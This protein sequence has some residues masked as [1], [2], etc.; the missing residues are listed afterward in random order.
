MPG[1]ADAQDAEE[2]GAQDDLAAD[3][4]GGHRRDDEPQ[5]VVIVER[6]EAGA[7]PVDEREDQADDPGRAQ[8]AARQQAAFQAQR[9]Q[10]VPDPLV[11]RQEALGAG[12]HLSE[13]R[14][15]HR[16]E[17][18]DDHGG[19]GDEGVDVEGHRADVERPGDDGRPD[20]DAQDEDHQAR[21][22]EQ[23]ARAEQQQE[24][25][26]TPPVPPG[27]QMRRPAPAVLGQRGRDLG[28]P[29][30]GQRRLDHKLAGE[31]HARGLQPEPHDTVPAETA[32][33]A[34]EVTDLAAEEQPADETEHRVAEVAVQRRH[35]PRLDAALK[36][37]A[38]HQV[39]PVPELLHERHQ[40]G[41]V[42]T[43]VRVAH[44]DAAT[45]GGHNPAH[46]GVAV[47]LLGD[48][49]HA[50]PGVGGQ[51]LA[52]VGA[53]V[54][55]DD[56]FAADLMLLQESHGLADARRDRLSLIETWHDDGQLH[57]ISLTAHGFTIR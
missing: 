46:Q 33:A 28:D 56:H 1:T 41:E 36:A 14:E 30:F 35:G 34:V 49:H 31:L 57:V 4:Q 19:R 24:A 42:V 17:A 7:V 29:L 3:D 22:E 10:N 39:G 53:A 23:P 47:A 16:L 27:V 38:H 32:Q 55:R 2:E 40:V 54:V 26:V 37:V 8:P 9:F 45:A 43:V 25:Q 50:C 18:D 20:H 13:Q 44:D 21:H 15:E 5:R 51:L 48:R 52:A 11:L 12:V 6:T